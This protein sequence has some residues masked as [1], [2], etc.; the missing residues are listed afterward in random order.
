MSADPD[1]LLSETR[2]LNKFAFAVEATLGY[3]SGG[4]ASIEACHLGLLEAGLSRDWAV[5][6]LGFINAGASSAEAWA[7]R[8][9]EDHW[10]RVAQASPTTA[11]Q[12]TPH[13]PKPSVED[14]NSLARYVK[15]R[16]ARGD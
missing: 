13:Q 14:F 16:Q 8:I 3:R 5:P 15:D 4:R 11:A 1:R 10:R 6:L 7:R 9:Y 2:L 12:P